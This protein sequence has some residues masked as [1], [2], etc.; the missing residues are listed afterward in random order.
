MMT[1]LKKGIILFIDL[2]KDVKSREDSQP[3]I[4]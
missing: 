1:Q 2:I 3:E 4:H